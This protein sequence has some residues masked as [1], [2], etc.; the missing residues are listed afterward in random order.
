MNN[1][2]LFLYLADVLPKI[3]I[4]PII[5]LIVVGFFLC[6][7]A[8]MAAD[9]YRGDFVMKIF[10]RGII[11]CLIG[12]ILMVTLQCAVPSRETFYMIAASEM[13]EQVVKTPEAQKMMDD[14]REVIQYQ[15]GKL[16]E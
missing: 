11:P 13:G 6:C 1:L 7:L 2:S 3:F 15:I 8:A 14:I 16:K 4:G 10:K 9:E 5:T 12:I